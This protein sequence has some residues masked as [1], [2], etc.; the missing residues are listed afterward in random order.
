M[1]MNFATVVGLGVLILSVGEC[2]G[3]AQQQPSEIV[4]SVCELAH[5]GAVV[6]GKRV[7]IAAIYETDFRHGAVLLDSGC[8]GSVIGLRYS[9]A[10]P[11]DPSLED[12]ERAQG[13]SADDP[14]HSRAS[15][16]EVEMSGEFAWRPKESRQGL[17]VV[18]KI[19]R[20]KEIPGNRVP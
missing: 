14:K 13:P 9:A 10:K 19:W 12:F 3:V 7:R 17:L 20:F 18:D 5:N 1:P 16:F 15:T 2:I 11:R 8:A 4:I 6:A